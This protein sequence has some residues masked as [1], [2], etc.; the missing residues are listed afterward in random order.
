MSIDGEEK[1][2]EVLELFGHSLVRK[3]PV[4][5]RIRSMPENDESSVN[6][7]EKLRALENVTMMS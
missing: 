6:F 2:A 7:L 4:V 1:T 5:V 3:S